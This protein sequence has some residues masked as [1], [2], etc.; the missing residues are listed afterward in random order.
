YKS[1]FGDNTIVWEPERSRIEKF[2]P[3]D[4][5]YRVIVSNVKQ[6]DEIREIEYEVIIAKPEYPPN[7][8][9]GFYWSS[10]DCNCIN[11]STTPS[12]ETGYDQ[13]LFVIRP[14]LADNYLKIER[15]GQSDIEPAQLFIF[16]FHGKVILQELIQSE[17]HV[18]T[19][20]YAPGFYFARLKTKSTWSSRKFTVVH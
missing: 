7:C 5:K 9:E 15:A 20:N 17:L 11:E 10:D 18:D 14:N 19:K 1:G 3:Y 13:E 16:D 2:S 12:Y 8:G 4:H 6:Q